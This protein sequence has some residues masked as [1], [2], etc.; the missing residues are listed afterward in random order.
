MKIPHCDGSASDCNRTLDEYRRLQDRWK[1]LKKE[2][3][4]FIIRAKALPDCTRTLKKLRRQ[5][6]TWIALDTGIS[7]K[8]S[9]S[10]DY[11]VGHNDALEGI[12]HHMKILEE[13]L[14]TLPDCTSNLQKL[15]RQQGMW[16][17]L[18]E[19]VAWNFLEKFTK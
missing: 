2:L 17:F 10:K 18:K 14:A 3:E 19:W 4:T 8:N 7:E 9:P 5:Q 1:A 12:L 13:R 6:G 11:Q 15:R 16:I